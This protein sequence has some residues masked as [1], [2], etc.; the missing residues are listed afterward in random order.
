MAIYP[1]LA[2]WGSLYA[3]LHGFCHTLTSTALPSAQ[4]TIP[5][6]QPPDLTLAQSQG[7]VS[8]PHGE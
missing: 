1:F 8:Q 4:S 5:T 7:R 2:P 3:W 6:C